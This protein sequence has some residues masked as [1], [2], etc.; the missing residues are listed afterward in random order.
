MQPL[1]AQIL[2]FLTDNARCSFSEIGRKVGL[3]TNAAAARV[4][5]L[6]DDGIIL[7]YTVVTSQDAPELRG[8]LQVF[9]DLR[10]HALTYYETFVTTISPIEPIIDAGHDRADDSLLRAGSGT[11]ALVRS[12]VGS[13]ELRRGARP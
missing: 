9:I 6:E 1:D 10:L 8:A 7:G 4:R 13:R 12:C 2:R 3:S 11:A 5:R